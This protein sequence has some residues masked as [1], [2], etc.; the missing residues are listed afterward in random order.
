MPRRPRGHR[1]KGA[2]RGSRAR[3]TGFYGLDGVMPDADTN[4]VRNI[5]QRLY[6]D[7]IALYIP[8]KAVK[9]LLRERTGTTDGTA[10]PGLEPAVPAG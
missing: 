7:G 6:D 8:F 4:A 1:A 9:A 2:A 5:L 10:H 3:A